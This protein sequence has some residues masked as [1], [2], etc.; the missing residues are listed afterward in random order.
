MNPYSFTQRSQLF[1]A[2]CRTHALC[3]RQLADADKV[4]RIERADTMD[5]VVAVLGPMEA[6]GGI[7]DVVSHGG[8]A[9]RKDRDVSSALAL[10]LELRAFEAFADLIVGDV[11][12]C[13]LR[14]VEGS[15]VRRSGNRD[16]PAAVSVTW[17]SARGNR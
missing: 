4:F 7:A 2:V 6:C 1:N 17:C 16:S 3:L 12:R 14:A 8:G 15:S 13:P 9:R 10:E 5:Q 11:Q